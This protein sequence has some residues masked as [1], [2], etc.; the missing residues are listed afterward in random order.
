[1]PNKKE[2]SRGDRQYTVHEQTEISGQKSDVGTSSKAPKH[3]TRGRA[4][5]SLR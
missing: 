5:P 3:N 1:L 4:L 2:V